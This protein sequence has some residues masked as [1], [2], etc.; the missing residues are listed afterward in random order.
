MKDEYYTGTIPW[1][2]KTCRFEEGSVAVCRYP[3]AESCTNQETINSYWLNPPW[4]HT[5]IVP[6]SSIPQ[7]QDVFKF[8][9]KTFIFWFRILFRLLHQRLFQFRLL[10][11][12]R[13][14]PSYKHNNSSSR[15]FR[16]SIPSISLLYHSTLYEPT[17]VINS[18]QHP[19]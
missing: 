9:L 15:S 5:R 11:R 3:A 19:Q 17:T 10:K 16:I 8:L 2:I 6:P 4:N 7:Q 14:L 18:A 12:Q 13:H 1:F